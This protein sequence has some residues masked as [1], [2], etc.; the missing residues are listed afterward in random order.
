MQPS[1]TSASAEA[2]KI[3]DYALGGELLE[4]RVEDIFRGIGLPIVRGTPQQEDFTIDP[5]PSFSKTI[6]APAGLVI[7]VKSSESGMLKKRYLRQLDDWVFTL[8]REGQIRKSGLGVRDTIRTGSLNY[9]YRGRPFAIDTHYNKHQ[10]KGVLIFNGPLSIRFEARDSGWLS[11]NEVR[12]AVDR[13][14]C[15]IPLEVL[16]KWEFNISSKAIDLERFWTTII[17]C[18]GV[19]TPP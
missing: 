9:S 3:E 6:S 11:E 5:L 14:F 1:T 13:N 10:R 19:L 12:F 18:E 16:L 15:I 8:S 4:H 17:G 2:S 7:E